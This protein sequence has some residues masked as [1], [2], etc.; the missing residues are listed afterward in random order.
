MAKAKCTNCGK[1]VE[2]SQL[3][4]KFLPAGG[5]DAPGGR[6]APTIPV[7]S[8]CNNKFREQVNV[9][10]DKLSEPSGEQE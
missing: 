2:E 7:C 3:E 4:R 5:E 1:E 10:A 9:G 6:E 8:D